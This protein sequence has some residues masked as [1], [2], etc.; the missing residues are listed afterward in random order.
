M[1]QL[2]PKI[3]K[4]FL[5][6][7]FEVLL[8]DAFGVLMDTEGPLPGAI[9]FI[10]HLNAIRKSYFIVT[11]SSLYSTQ[12]HQANYRRK[13]LEIAQ[14]AIISAGSIL[15]TWLRKRGLAG[16]RF[17]V[18]GAQS[19]YELL[20]AGGAHTVDP[21]NEDDVDVIVLAGQ[22]EFDFVRGIDQAV[23]IIFRAL[24]NQKPLEVI[25]T[26]PDMIYPKNAN[27]YGITG[28]CLALIVETAIRLRFPTSKFQ[29][30]YIGKP[31]STLFEEARE[32]APFG[33]MVMI[34]DQLQTDIR[35]A[36]DFGIES[37]LIGTG[38]TKF[39][40]DIFNEGIIPTYL[41]E[42]LQ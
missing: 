26:N 21:Y 38:V 1:S 4:E 18:L 11:N 28:G 10:N 9:D 22:E 19:T 15:P 41:L 31:Y 17:L 32:R 40:P 2:P 20:R 34:G 3:S 37:V 5:I 33:R 39:A 42:N 12:Q 13:G 30:T 6:Q 16:K 7:N 36:R 8:I 23:S 29:L 24:E 25:V 27:S 14:E 35:G